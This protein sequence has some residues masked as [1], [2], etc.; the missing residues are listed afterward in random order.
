MMIANIFSVFSQYQALNATS[1][2]IPDPSLPPFYRWGN[3]GLGRLSNLTK[4]WIVIQTRIPS[5]EVISCPF[6]YVQIEIK[7]WE[8][9]GNDSREL[10]KITWTSAGGNIKYLTMICPCWWVKH[11]HIFELIQYSWSRGWWGAE[12][13]ALSKHS[14]HVKC[15]YHGFLVGLNS[16]CFYLQKLFSYFMNGV[17]VKSMDSA[18]AC[19]VVKTTRTSTPQLCDLGKVT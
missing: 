15:C 17:V 11:L 5:P 6:L 4:V 7:F 10:V 19:L 14:V 3:W 12:S 2:V 1:S 18:I 9:Q 13:L 16:K 8:R